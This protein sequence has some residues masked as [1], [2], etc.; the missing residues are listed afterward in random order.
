MSILI[1]S[2]SNTDT[3]GFA[4]LLVNAVNPIK[5]YNN[6]EF[7]PR[8]RFSKRA[9]L[10]L[11]KML[12][13][14]PKANERSNPVPPS[15]HLLI[16]LRFY[17]TGTFQVITGDFDNVSQATLSRINTCASKIITETLFPQLVKLPNANEEAAVIKEFYLIAQFPD[18]AVQ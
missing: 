2:L 11:L 8:Y 13:L 5:A 15:L 10:R 17:G 14:G 1:Q 6:A 12:P 7:L 9:L 4:K 3:T 18:V 16:A